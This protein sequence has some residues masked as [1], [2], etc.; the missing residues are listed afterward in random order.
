M[1]RNE[2]K[3][4]AA[5]NLL[6][7]LL[8]TALFFAGIILFY[9]FTYGVIDDPF[10]ATV[11]NGAYTGT[12]DAHVVYIKYPLAWILKTLF[13]IAPDIN[14]HFFLLAGCFCVCVFVVVYRI[15][16]SVRKFRNKI[17]LS[18]LFLLLFWLCMA[19]MV[20]TVHYSMC[21]AVLTGTGL[22]YFATIRDN[23][24]KWN[25][26]L[27]YLAVLLMLW[28]A[29]ALRAR[30]LF[31]LLPLGGVL[32]LYKFWKASP[33]FTKK[34]ILR[35]IF[36]PVILFVGLGGLELMHNAQYKSEDWQKFLRFNDARTTLYDFY[37]LPEYE[38]NKDFYESLQISEARAYMYEKYY[39]EFQDGVP[40]DALS[41]I[42]D[43]RVAEYA[44]TMPAGK[45]IGETLK[46]LPINLTL[47][48]YAPV[49]WIAAALFLFLLVLA[50]AARKWKTFLF[51]W[52]GI[53]ASL[54]PWLWMIYMGKPTSRVTM[55]IWAADLLFAA[56]ILID[57]SK[58]IAGF[59]E[60]KK[61]KIRKAGAEA[62][63]IVLFLVFA[64]ALFAGI[65]S[66]YGSVKGSLQR[67]IDSGKVRSAL[68][69][70]CEAR[71]EN[72]YLC[73]SEIVNGL[74]FD[75]K[76]VDGSLQNLYWPG[77]WPAM[78][79]QGR[80][81]WARFGI[82]DIEKAAAEE[83]NI[84]IIA[85]AQ[86]DM[87]YWTKFYRETYPEIGLVVEEQPELNG[88]PFKVYQLQRQGN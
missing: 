9:D 64:A 29:Y 33:V 6:T 3:K 14:W 18:V 59:V 62:I 85:F 67:S 23:A 7:A 53:L 71:P 21:A 12:P 22:F 42:A 46:A 52:L 55:G 43:Y 32:F 30:T 47:K 36:V 11:L 78:M 39:L 44:E 88:V 13:S 41:E 40:E 4:G 72:L 86:T 51:L 24:G 15:C 2:T 34:N 70:W 65:A 63:R 45:R 75:W 82:K 76:E 77:G 56:A 73:E 37:R 69:Q 48:T 61:E 74:G 1:S 58:E 8:L 81:I 19:K 84:Y 17:L 38:K 35:W 31:M 49:N 57:H 54:I 5:E 79:P 16:S 25:R 10:I 50:A 28:T 87:E 26:I 68:E 60:K 66:D 20:L 27:S 80:E 83:D